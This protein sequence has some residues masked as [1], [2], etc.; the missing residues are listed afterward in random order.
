[1]ALARRLLRL[2]LVGLPPLLCARLDVGKERHRQGH[3]GALGAKEAPSTPSTP[4]SKKAKKSV[5]LV[6]AGLARHMEW[7]WP[8]WNESFIMPNEEAGYEFTIVFS[9]NAALGCREGSRK[10]PYSKCEEPVDREWNVQEIKKWFAPRAVTVLDYVGRASW[11]DRV[12]H[13]LDNIEA[14][15]RF[16]RVV[17]MRPDIVLGWSQQNKVDPLVLRLDE[18][19]E[20]KPGFSIVDGSWTLT[21]RYFHNRDIDFMQILCPGEKLLVYKEALRNPSAACSEEPIPTLPPGFIS[22]KRWRVD[23]GASK[24]GWRLHGFSAQWCE[25]VKTFQISNI[26]MSNWDDDYLLS[27]MRRGRAVR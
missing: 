10:Y 26:S 11:W 6:V 17:A 12:H 16:D 25:F 24:R 22:K 15:A 7:H 13:A 3:K 8:K 23:K 4:G 18:M 27:F 14:G 19:C 5:L 1:M 2:M 9:T 21:G 20:K